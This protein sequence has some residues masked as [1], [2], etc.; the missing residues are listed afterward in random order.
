MQEMYINLFFRAKRESR[1]V[2]GG[3]PPNLI[4]DITYHINTYVLA[5]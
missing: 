3:S 5:I 4:I 2:I 1:G